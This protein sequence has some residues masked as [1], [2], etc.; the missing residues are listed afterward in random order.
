MTNFRTLNAGIDM[1]WEQVDETLA[2]VPQESLGNR[3]GTT[4]PVQLLPEFGLFLGGVRGQ[5][6]KEIGNIRP[7]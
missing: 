4:S 2:R 5:R 3:D 7:G 6:T 1:F